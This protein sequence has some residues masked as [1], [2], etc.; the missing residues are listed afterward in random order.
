MNEVCQFQCVHGE[1]DHLLYFVLSKDV[2]VAAVYVQ[3]G[4]VE[5]GTARGWV[6][7]SVAEVVVDYEEHW[8]L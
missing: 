6:T 5:F 3:E 4:H 8:R 1:V 2:D 7:R